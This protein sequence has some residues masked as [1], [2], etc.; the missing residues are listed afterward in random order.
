[1]AHDQHIDGQFN[2][3]F[4]AFVQCCELFVIAVGIDEQLFEQIVDL[5]SGQ[6]V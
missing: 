3:I 6:P 4:D 2:G 1:M 5:L